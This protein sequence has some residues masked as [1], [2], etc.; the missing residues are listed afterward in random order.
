MSRHTPFLRTTALAAVLATSG[1]LASAQTPAAPQAPSRITPQTAPQADRQ[2]RMAEHRARMAERHQQHL[3]Q[4]KARLQLT[5]EQ[6]PA[7]RAYQARMAPPERQA[8]GYR[9]ERPDLATMTTPQRIEHLKAGQARR[10][11]AHEQRMEATLSF[12]RVLSPAQQ[13]VFDQATVPGF[14]RAGLPGPH[15][16]GHGPGHSAAPKGPRS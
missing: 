13:Q 1:L 10:Q 9:G 6:E 14:M 11:A 3:E 16:H 15:R 7:W 2:E 12:Y 8:D 4:L 5:P